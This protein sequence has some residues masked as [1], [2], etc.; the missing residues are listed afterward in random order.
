MELADNIT[1]IRQTLSKTIDEQISTLSEEEILNHLSL[2]PTPEEFP[3]ENIFQDLE[4]EIRA[5]ILDLEEKVNFLFYRLG[6][7]YSQIS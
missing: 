5:M 6:N 7:L 3:V 1:N 4:R 2:S